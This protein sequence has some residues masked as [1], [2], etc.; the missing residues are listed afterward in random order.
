MFRWVLSSSS[1]CMSRNWDKRLEGQ[2][3]R[4]SIHTVIRALTGGF[5]HHHYW[6]LISGIKR[7][8]CCVKSSMSGLLSAIVVFMTWQAPLLKSTDWSAAARK[9]G[10]IALTRTAVDTCVGKWLH[11]L[12]SHQALGEP[13]GWSPWTLTMN[14]WATGSFN[15]NWVSKKQPIMQV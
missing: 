2:G 1:S 14:N 7:N 9:A 11:I 5:W 8:V 12:P 3:W 10:N 4:T 6:H 13:Q 15:A